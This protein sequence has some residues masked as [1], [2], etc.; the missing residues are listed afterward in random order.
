MDL[1]VF[2]EGITD[3]PVSP[4]V[5]HI[6]QYE[7]EMPVV[8]ARVHGVLKDV[9]GLNERISY[10][11]PDGDRQLSVGAPNATLDVSRSGPRLIATIRFETALDYR[12]PEAQPA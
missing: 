2:C 9:V 6:T 1:L 3:W 4:Q 8:N 5:V 10:T 11:G 12:A 7:G